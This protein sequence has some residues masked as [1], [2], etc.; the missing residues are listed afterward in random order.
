[1]SSLD[2]FIYLPTHYI[3]PITQ[4]V[5]EIVS[6]NKLSIQS[7]LN[8]ITTEIKWWE[9]TE[10]LF[11]FNEAMPNH[12]QTLWNLYA[13]QSIYFECSNQSDVHCFKRGFS[14]T[15]DITVGSSFSISLTFPIDTKK[16][17]DLLIG[18]R[19]NF[20]VFSTIK[21]QKT[22]QEKWYV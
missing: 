10:D 3:N 4:D 8:G 17:A 20:V 18:E 14:I 11:K 5:K 12:D 6:I 13:D 7:H 2:V 9:N 15:D 21:A 22:V 19:D 16:V 1:M